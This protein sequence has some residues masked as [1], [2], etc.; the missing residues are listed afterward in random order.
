MKQ[1][2]RHVDD[3]GNPYVTTDL[4]GYMITRLPLL[5][6]SSGFSAEERRE[7]G[8]TGLTAPHISTLE[9]QVDRAYANFT[10]SLTGLDK[11]VYLRV[12]QDRDETLFY[13]LLEQHLEEMLPIIYTPTVAEAVQNFSL[14]YRWPRGLVISTENIDQVDEVLEQI[15]LTDVRLAVATD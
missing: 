3:Q 11:H 13:A 4:S 14:I 2:E 8:L 12:L 1:F 5:N 15:P 6:K 9:E 10:R 7:L